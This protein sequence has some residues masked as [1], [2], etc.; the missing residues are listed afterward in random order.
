MNIPELT[1]RESEQKAIEMSKEFLNSFPDEGEI[2]ISDL[3]QRVLEW[4]HAMRISGVKLVDFQTATELVRRYLQIDEEHWALL[5]NLLA[6]F[7][8]SEHVGTPNPNN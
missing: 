6:E 4:Q 8:V 1:D 2:D 5:L 3:G 7:L